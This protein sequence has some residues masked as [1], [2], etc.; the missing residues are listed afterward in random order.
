MSCGGGGVRKKGWDMSCEGEGM[1]YD[2]WGRLSEEE[3]M[4]YNGGV[5]SLFKFT[6]YLLIKSWGY[7]VI[8]TDS[9]VTVTVSY[10]TSLGEFP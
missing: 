7:T 10:L 8:Y 9:A 4:R 5:E 1:R 2:F 3:G 6:V